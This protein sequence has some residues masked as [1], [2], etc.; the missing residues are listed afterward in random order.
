MFLK[1]MEEAKD[2]LSRKARINEQEGVKRWERGESTEQ[3]A[4]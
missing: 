1:T 4:E 2:E 3:C